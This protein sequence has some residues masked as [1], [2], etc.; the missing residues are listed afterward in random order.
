MVGWGLGGDLFVYNKDVYWSDPASVKLVE[1]LLLVSVRS[2]FV[3]V[4]I[5][6]IIPLARCFNTLHQDLIF[7]ICCDCCNFPC[8][9]LLCCFGSSPILSHFCPLP[10]AEQNPSFLWR[11]LP[12]PPYLFLPS[13][14]QFS[15]EVT[16]AAH[17]AVPLLS[18]ECQTCTGRSSAFEILFRTDCCFCKSLYMVKTLVCSFGGKKKKDYLWKAE[19]YPNWKKTQKTTFSEKGW[20]NDF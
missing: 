3:L 10:K 16:K 1:F 7:L 18:G 5:R 13:P 15:R 2:C 9:V 11:F 12:L 8:S 14:T 17:W 4:Y 6:G 20:E 19:S